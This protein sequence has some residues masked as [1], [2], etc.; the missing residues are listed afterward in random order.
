MDEQNKPLGIGTALAEARQAA[1]LQMSDVVVALKIR[2]VHLQALEDEDFDILPG[3]AYVL[4]FIGTYG[5]FLS[6]DADALVAKYKDAKKITDRRDEMLPLPVKSGTDF[7][8]YIITGA[9]LAG[10]AVL[11]VMVW[12]LMGYKDM[13]NPAVFSATSSSAS[14][15]AS[16]SASSP[17]SSL[18]G[19]KKSTTPQATKKDKAAS[20]SAS[21][22]DVPKTIDIRAIGR[23]WMRVENN[24]GGVL[25]SSIVNVGDK[26]T[27][28]TDSTYTIATHDAGALAFFLGDMNL[29]VVGQKAQLLTGH[30]I[31]PAHIVRGRN[32][33]Q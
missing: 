2:E 10:L 16:S 8:P 26:F 29:G 25:F 23:T 22:Q 19:E 24:D 20:A 12:F 32:N 9:V 11:G 3:D 14:S 31:T 17:A 18:A 21:L 1:G 4:G 6:L 5:G 27:L 28:S 15:L 13:K 7:M 33:A 30:I